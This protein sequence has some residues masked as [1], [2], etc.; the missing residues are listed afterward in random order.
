MAAKATGYLELNIQGFQKGI[1]SAKT[2]MASLVTSAA[3]AAGT[4]AAAFASYKIVDFFKEGTQEAINFGNEM[5]IAGQKL[6]G[7]DPGKL[8]LVQKSFEKLGLSA[9]EARSEV[10]NFI[11]SGRDISQVFGGTENYAKALQEVSKQY[12]SQADVLSSSAEKFSKV[13]DKL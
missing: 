10:N 7:F 12:G 1:D 4:I 6:G 11:D 3:A 9:G 2:S 5:Y 8:L 13:F